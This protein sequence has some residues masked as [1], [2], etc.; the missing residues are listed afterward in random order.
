M[1]WKF[2]F[3]SV[4]PN[5]L[6]FSELKNAFRHALRSFVC[7]HRQ[8]RIWNKADDESVYGDGKILMNSAASAKCMHVCAMC[9]FRHE[10]FCFFFFFEIFSF[11]DWA[12][13]F[14]IENSNVSLE[15]KSNALTKHRLRRRLD[16]N[17]NIFFLLAHE[18]TIDDCVECA[19]IVNKKQ[20]QKRQNKKK[21][22]RL[23]LFF[24]VN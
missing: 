17:N 16:E 4:E 11:I 22:E 24:C 20:K 2:T 14:M 5:K 15:L 18:Q 3:I 7:G 13:V 1:Q 10:T 21:K 12:T 19:T 6:Q 9:M 8:N 23:N